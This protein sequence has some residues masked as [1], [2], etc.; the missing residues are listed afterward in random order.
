MERATQKRVANLECERRTRDHSPNQVLETSPRFRDL[1]R[2]SN[3]ERTQA[4]RVHGRLGHVVSLLSK[5]HI[6]RPISRDNSPDLIL[7]SPLEY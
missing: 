5:T 6:R 2:E 3:S 4:A 7:K 1:R